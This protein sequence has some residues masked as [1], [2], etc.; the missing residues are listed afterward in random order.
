MLSHNKIKDEKIF[1]TILS[2]SQDYLCSTDDYKPK[3]FIN[4]DT[5]FLLYP[6][7]LRYLGNNIKSSSCLL[8]KLHIIRCKLTSDVVSVLCEALKQHFTLLLLSFYDN[9]LLNN[10]IFKLVSVIKV[11]SKLN[12]VS[13][14]EKLLSDE[15][16]DA[17]YG[18]LTA[19]CSIARVM[20]VSATKIQ[21]L[22]TANH[23][24]MLAV[25]YLN[26][27]QLRECHITYET[28]AK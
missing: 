9:G 28:I 13:I 14:Y 6:S 15:D 3:S 17:L 16:A 22:S 5:V 2:L 20:V 12:N 26:S 8:V 7:P 21:A 23:Q 24:I 10:D 27:F 18:T 19:T 25:T 11:L 4:D 1:N